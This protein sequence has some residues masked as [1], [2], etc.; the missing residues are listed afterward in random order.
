MIS[1]DLDAPADLAEF[2]HHARRLIAQRSAPETV[3]FNFGDGQSEL[4]GSTASNEQRFDSARPLQVPKS[5]V[6]LAERVICHSNPARFSLLY[7][8]LWRLQHSRDFLQDNAD[9]DVFMARKFAKSVQRDMHKMKAFVR[10]RKLRSE[11]TE[12]YVAWFEPEH[13]IVEAVA[14]F[15]AKRFTGMHWSIL[16]PLRSVHWDGV[17]L[18]FAPGAP[19]SAAPGSDELEVLWRTY[20]RSIFNPARLKVSAMRTEMPRKFWKN[21]PEARLI[22]ELIR[23]GQTAAHAPPKGTPIGRQQA[24]EWTSIAAARFAARPG[25]LQ[26]IHAGVRACSRCELSACATQ[27]VCGSGPS[28][29]ALFIVGEQPGDEEDRRGKPFV[30]PAGKLL[31]RAM[32]ETGI[33]RADVYLTN[34]VK[35]FKFAQKGERRIHKTPS[36]REV[37]HCRW[38]LDLELGQIRPRT[39]V[40]LGATA[41]RSLTGRAWKLHEEHGL[42]PGNGDQPAL[43]TTIHP[44]Y[45]LRSNP[46]GREARYKILR[47]DLLAAQRSLTAGG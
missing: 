11:E 12:S 29:A 15:F 14:P 46:A 3:S 4:F 26:E 39:V 27:A 42:Q 47:D 41:A 7:R 10:F 30:G 25:S 2:R 24:A 28:S 9:D 34:A 17:R 21:L 31:D 45:V 23:D 32:E 44:A 36:L 20:Y 33:D 38:W 22:P 1:V 35:H 37:E 6:E 43:V 5:F 13:H 40:T 18:L 16:T 8:L 19:S